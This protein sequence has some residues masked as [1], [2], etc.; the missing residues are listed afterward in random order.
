MKMYITGFGSIVP[1]SNTNDKLWENLKKKKQQFEKKELL[2]KKEVLVAKDPQYNKE[3]YNIPPKKFNY[4]DSQMVY[5]MIASLNCVKDAKLEEVLKDEE[6]RKRMGV[7]A[8]SFFAQMEFGIK[9]VK[10]VEIDRS[11]KI[12]P[13]TGMAFYYGSNVGEISNLLKTQ[14][15]NCAVIS[16]SNIGFDSLG[17]IKQMFDNNRNDI[18]IAGA[19]ENIV[20]ELLYHSLESKGCLAQTEYRPYYQSNQGTAFANG[21]M[22]CVVESEKSVKERGIQAKAEIKAFSMKNCSSCFFEVSEKI[23]PY[24]KKAIDE[25]LTQSGLSIDDIDLVVPTASGLK[26][27]DE[28]EKIA[29][30]ELFRGKKEIMYSPKLAV[31]Y[32]LSYNNFLD[33][34]VASKCLEEGIIPGMPFEMKTGDKE[35]DELWVKGEVKRNIRNVLLLHKSFTD[36]KISTAILGKC[37]RN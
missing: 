21:S 36:G 23:I 12:S 29:L 32:G 28:Y 19:G 37:E 6:K 5:C 22:M 11:I 20:Y 31:G 10:K 13:Y 34:F 35:F 26:E 30:R 18:V 3:D 27:D 7:V 24:Y 16:G 1:G 8:G 14:G 15:E 33:M 17:I 25:S 2:Q 9:Q 4:M